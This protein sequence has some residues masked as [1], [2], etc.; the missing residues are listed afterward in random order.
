[1]NKYKIGIGLCTYKRPEMLNTCLES[2]NKI[3]VPDNAEIVILIADNDSGGSAKSVVDD[4]RK[5]TEILLHYEIEP[6]RGIPCAR[7]NVIK[8]GINQ[9]ITELAF[10][11]DDEYV[12]SEWLT[13]IWEYY[14]NTKADVVRGFVKTVYSELTPDWIIKGSFYQRKLFDENRNYES[15][16]TN[17]V[18]F[19]FKK[20]CVDLKIIFDESFGLKGGSDSD[21]FKKVYNCGLS[22]RATN[23]AV[24]YEVLDKDRFKLSYLLKRKFRTRNLESSYKKITIKKRLIIFLSALFDIV[25]GI[26][27]LPLN[28]FRGKHKII[29]SL[30]SLTSGTGKLLGLFT[31][32]IKWE[33][34]KK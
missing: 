28:C 4:F 5:N 2:L 18:L 34:Y 27:L 22:I 29:S 13:N 23:K 8:Q 33:E 17:N 25:K 10:I 6:A 7:N 21:F 32:H 20:I 19:D 31:I 30:C 26:S 9:N 3:K 15:A 24:V 12:D 11:D 1:M 16:S 14:F